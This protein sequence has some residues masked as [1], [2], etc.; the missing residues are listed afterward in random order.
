MPAPSAI[1]PINNRHILVH[2]NN[3]LYTANHDVYKYIESSRTWKQISDLTTSCTLPTSY[4]LNTFVVAPSDPNF[5][6]ATTGGPTWDPPVKWVLF[7][8]TNVE[9]AIPTWTDI[10]NN[11]GDLQWRY[12]TSIE[13]DPNNPNRVWL[14]LNGGKV[15]YSSDGGTTWSDFSI[16]L[17]N[18]TINKLIYQNGSDDILY[19]ATD[20]GV[21]YYDK[22]S[23]IWQLYNSGLPNCI[24][25]ELAID[26]YNGQIIAA[27]HGRGVW[28]SPLVNLIYNEFSMTLSKSVTWDKSYAF[29]ASITVPVGKTL[30]IT[31]DLALK[32]GSKIL[33]QSGGS[34]I[35]TGCNIIM[36]DGNPFLGITVENGGFLSLSST[37]ISAYDIDVKTGGTL[38][39]IGGLTITGNHHID[40]ES[41][42]YICIDNGITINLT[43]Q[44]SAINLHNGY[45]LGV[46]TTFFTDPGTC[47]STIVKNGIGNINLFNNNLIIQ[48]EILTGIQYR[49]GNN[50][51]AG[52]L[53]T[54]TLPG[55]PVTIKNGANVTFDADGII[56][57]DWGFEVENG[58][59]FEAK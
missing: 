12:I 23:G 11:C 55:G 13:I 7:K 10:T 39:I 38:R 18:L 32:P 34:L 21:Y 51:S 31:K 46:N 8:G 26:Y 45:H 19:A 57:L 3:V 54:V 9:S 14:S 15:D 5:V 43:D 20:G 33:V 56:V 58:A 42:G 22:T 35:I 36:T 47:M 1:A 30:T 17:P 37:S 25:Q 16:G 40:I 41:G 6:Y 50:I 2:N 53:I 29:G 44:L 27:T 52:T 59:L 24:V 4:K 28:I 48:K 49:H